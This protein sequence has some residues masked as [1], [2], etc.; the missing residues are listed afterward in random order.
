MKSMRTTIII[1]GIFLAL[2]LVMPSCEKEATKAPIEGTW[3]FYKFCNTQ[4][5]SGCI[6]K[7]DRDFTEVLEI[8]GRS[9]TRFYDDSVVFSEDFV[10]N[11]SL[12]VYGNDALAQ[13]FRLQNDTLILAD[14]CFECNVHFYVRRK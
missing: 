2:F 6:Y 9:F 3:D 4:N 8:D 10:L 7:E 14:T 5:F 13:S 11:D 1:S 12:I